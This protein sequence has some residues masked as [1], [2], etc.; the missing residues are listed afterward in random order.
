M[1]DNKELAFLSKTLGTINLEVPIEEKIEDLK[2]KEWNKEKVYEDFKKLRFNRYIERFKLNELV[3]AIKNSTILISIMFANNEIGTIQPIK[4]IGQI[5]K[6]HNIIFHTDAVQAV[7]NVK[8]DVQ[9]MNIDLLSMSGHKFYGPKGIGA[10]YVRKGIDFE[11]IQ[12]SWV[13]GL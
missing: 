2:V 1:L 9:K 8:I 4:E 6:E 13:V 11:R 5:A 12:E 7:G 3:S 10:L